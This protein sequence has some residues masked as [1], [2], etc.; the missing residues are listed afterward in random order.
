[1]L[2]QFS[3][4]WWVLLVN[5]IIALILGLFAVFSPQDTLVTLA[6][7]FG[8]LVIIAGLILGI[9]VVNRMRKNEPY[10]W[11]L[12][13]AIIII[14]LG[15]VILLYTEQTLM[16]FAII[17]GIWAITMGVMQFMILASIKDEIE[18]KN[19]ILINALITVAFGIVLF[20]NPF[21]GMKIFTILIG[22]AALIIGVMMIMVAFS[23]KKVQEGN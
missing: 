18:N 14:I 6:K 23:V 1:M 12:I 10:T 8:F 15:A 5:G 19:I 4:N 9:G 7:Y 11:L 16:I 21:T 17:I 22:V 13:E 20:F 3:K 2:I